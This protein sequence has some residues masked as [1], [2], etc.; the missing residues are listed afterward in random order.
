MEPGNEKEHTEGG[1]DGQAQVQGV[2]R[3]R[4]RAMVAG[5]VSRVVGG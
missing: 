4:P 5:N 3:I 1:Q 2:L